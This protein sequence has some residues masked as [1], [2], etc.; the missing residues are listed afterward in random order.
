MFYLCLYMTKI[1]FFLHWRR[2]NSYKN[3]MCSQFSNSISNVRLR[4]K[5]RYRIVLRMSSSQQ[6]L[7]QK[8]IL[9]YLLY[10]DRLI[11]TAIILFLVF[12]GRYINAAVS[13]HR[14]GNTINCTKKL[15][16]YFTAFIIC[17]GLSAVHYPNRKGKHGRTQ[18]LKQIILI[19]SNNTVKG[20]D[21]LLK[22]AIE[23]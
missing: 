3:R 21:I 9:L 6:N 11:E 7:I 12:Q 2:V 8:P 19:L 5:A 23:V 15:R 4:E 14:Y 20:S 16:N 10:A 13:Q 18:T 1:S 22:I 17:I